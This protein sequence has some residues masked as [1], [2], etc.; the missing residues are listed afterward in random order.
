MEFEKFRHFA[1]KQEHIDI[2]SKLSLAK[3]KLGGS[4]SD[5]ISLKTVPLSFL[6]SHQSPHPT[7]NGFKWPDIIPD[8]QGLTFSINVVNMND[9]DA[10]MKH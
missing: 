4:L 3:R 7:N 6:R 9:K 2:V 1:G 5:H 8:S 10:V